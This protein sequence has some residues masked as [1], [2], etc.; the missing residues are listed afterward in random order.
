MK[1][2]RTRLLV[3]LAL[4]ACPCLILPAVAWASYQ[5][6]ASYSL[7]SKN[8]SINSIGLKKMRPLFDST[9]GL[10]YNRLRLDYV[11]DVVFEE[12]RFD[13]TYR[14]LVSMKTS[15]FDQ[16]LSTEWEEGMRTNWRSVVIRNFNRG[17]D[18]AGEEEGLLPDIQLPVDMPT[19]IARVIGRGGGLKVRGSNRI[20]FGG[21]TTFLDPEPPSESRR[22]SHFP[23]VAMDQNLRVTVE[24]T[25]GEK[26]HVCADHDRDGEVRRTTQVRVRYDC[27]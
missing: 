20:A 13:T 12:A 27:E 8:E 1:V 15:T 26:I 5:N 6:S 2:S 16:F 3:W 23:S 14:G 25:V 9:K 10:I 4:Q 21:S 22:T 11:N 17:F 18:T 7:F 19:P 24:G